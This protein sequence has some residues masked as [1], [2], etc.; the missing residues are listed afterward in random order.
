MAT[1]M[2]S[3]TLPY[4]SENR[5]LIPWPFRLPT[6]CLVGCDQL[7]RQSA[8]SPACWGVLSLPAYAQTSWTGATSTDW[9]TGTNWNTGVVPTAA[10]LVILNTITPNPT[11]VSGGAAVA[12]ILFVAQ[13][14]TGA[15]TIVNGT[16]N[17]TGAD[18]GEGVG[19]QGT[20]MVTGVGSTWT[21]SNL[22]SVGTNGTGTLT[23]ENG[24]AVS[25]V[26]GF[27]GFATGS[28]GAV[29]VTGAGST[30]TNSGFLSV[31]NGGTGTLTLA[32]GGVVSSAN[33]GF[34]GSILGSQGAV[35]VTGAGSSWI[36]SGLLSVGNDGTGALAVGNGGVVT[37]GLLTVG[38]S[39]AGTVTIGNGG[40]VSSGLLTVGQF[41]TGTLTIAN[42]GNLITSIPGADIGNSV[43]SQGMV[44]VTGAG[45]T[46]TN[47]GLLSVGTNGAGTLTIANGGAV[48]NTDGFIGFATGS[49][50]AVTVTGAG[51]IW[52]N[53]GA[54]FLGRFGAGAMTIANGGTVNVGGG[55][56][57]VFVANQAGS[58]G[59]L[60]IGAVPGD[61]AA[62]PG[63]LNAAALSFGTG[64]GNLNFNHT[65]TNYVFAT[66]IS[67]NGAV[68]QNGPGTT[69]LSATSTYTGATAV[70]AGTLIVDGSIASS[71]LTTVSSGATLGGS[72]T[73]G[74]TIINSGG[75]FAPGPSGAPGTMT[76][77]GN[78]AFQSGAL[79]VVQVNPT[80]ATTTNVSGTASLAGTVHANFL[81]GS[82]IQRSYTILTA[83]GGRSG[84]FDALAT[85]GLPVNFQAS[86]SY[87]GNTAVL[88][89]TA[90]LVPPPSPPTPPTPPSPP[91][92]PTPPGPPIP[93]GPPPLTF[94]INQ[95]NVGNAIDNFFNN[96]GALPSSFLPLF[97]L[98]GNNLTSALDQLSGEA[99]TGAQKVG[100][101]LTDQF[102]NLMLD[103]FVDGRT[104]VG[105][106][107]R[108][109]L[110][111]APERAPLPEDIALAYAKVLK[112]PPKPPTF[113]QR[114][115]VWGA[116]YG[117][118]N[119]TDGDLAV[120][121]SHDLSART[122]G[123]AAGLDYHL[124]PSTVVGFALAGAGTD[125]SL[126]QGLGGGKSDAFQAGIYGATKSGPAYLAA[127]FAFTNHWMS[128]DR[129]SFAG[130]H[131]TAD[132]NAQSY[133]GRLE[134]GY[135]F[136]TPYGGITPY[137]AIQA[138][139]FHTPS[140]TETGV[141]PNGFALTFNG[142]DA[143][144][145]RSELGARFDRVLAVYSN[146]VLALRGRVAWAHDWVS[147][148]TLA[149]VFQ[150]LPGASF[151]VNGAL[152]VKDAAL[153]SA[154]GELRIANGIT[155]LAKF[156]GE[157]ASHSSTY[158][159]TGTVR[160]RW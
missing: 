108:P 55:A 38:Q 72:G 96:G 57:T 7:P 50:G 85:A 93:A 36:N 4:I 86:L 97:S 87:P 8:Y 48:S 42:G 139:S 13:T 43:G 120:V 76:V 90:Q 145:T 103:P 29:T 78:L 41:G 117:G 54:L 112:T 91:G 32:S 113:E 126:S 45:S 152:P 21:N 82:F 154:G 11:S 26:N 151:I 132:F 3:T 59:T 80:T 81:P 77:A 111:F 124:S 131:L 122:A 94:T 19:S 2:T 150:T 104:G 71:S 64:I 35:T 65:A 60:S 158:A 159:G 137:G 118:S 121:G 28:Q 147:D 15:L 63:I 153:A 160:Y 143:T 123:G 75:A 6:S 10:D 18:I 119:R 142:R 79:Y 73:V 22:L 89:L 16:M 37:S 74:S 106:V 146:V 23:I 31:G 98:T 67:G 5:G 20:A 49:Q 58:T 56:G 136:G 14:G 83:A 27:V 9:F 144:D 138:Q 46:W 24:G 130:D 68:Q 53:S 149:A 105:G 70:N 140:Y 47:S 17:I 66:P 125:W 40:V 33:G 134:G 84:T 44:T 115:T 102:L 129:I 127:A 62:A 69:I 110:G 1:A 135:R 95:L 128:T 116:G 133:G 114:W 148:P 156:D 100:F 107:D 12:N 157:F 51:S 61:P 141:I 155:L 88:N 99:A 109:A 30:W 25:N 52:T 39:G 34:I 92:P 101:Q